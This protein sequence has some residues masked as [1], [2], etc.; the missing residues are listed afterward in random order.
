MRDSKTDTRSGTFISITSGKT[1][2]FNSLDDLESVLILLD[3]C[4]HTGDILFDNSNTSFTFSLMEKSI[5]IGLLDY[6]RQ[7]KDFDI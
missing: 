6:M 7:C 3:D 2:K 1:Y 5:V 4:K